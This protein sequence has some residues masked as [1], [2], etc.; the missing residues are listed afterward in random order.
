MLPE[1]AGRVLY[2]RPT[3]NGVTGFVAATGESY[4]CADAA[5]DPHY[6]DGAAGA[7]AR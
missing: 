5:T 6:I 1:A 3:G 2:A 4:L 7:A